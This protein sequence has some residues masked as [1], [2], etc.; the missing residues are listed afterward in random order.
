MTFN[1]TAHKEKEC[2]ICG[3]LFIGTHAGK[4]CSEPCKLI[5]RRATYAKYFAK[6]KDTSSYKK[7]RRSTNLKSNYGIT[8]VE[9]NIMLESQGG[10]C[11]ICDATKE[12][13]GRALPVDH[14]HTTGKI[15]GILCD[16]CNRSIGLLGDDID[17]L[18][19]AAFYLLE[20]N[21]ESD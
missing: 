18:I 17:L 16:T 21:E 13:N 1:N 2:H 4:Y 8:L 11:K 7:A 14:C 9:Y 15:R 10:T 5:S 20:T 19:S 12:T 6:A 3:T